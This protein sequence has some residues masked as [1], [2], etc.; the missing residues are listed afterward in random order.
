MDETDTRTE[1]LTRYP[2]A[3][4]H[5]VPTLRNPFDA[6]SPE[7]PQCGRANFAFASLGAFGAGEKLGRTLQGPCRGLHKGRHDRLRRSSSATGR[8]TPW[9][10][11]QPHGD[12]PLVAHVP[13][14]EGQDA[15][16]GPC[17]VTGHADENGDMTPVSDD[18]IRLFEQMDLI[19]RD[20][21]GGA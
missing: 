20:E 16:C 2:P 8:Q 18:V 12:L 14:A 21:E 7:P 15:I 19:R 6:V 4:P 3:I 17:F 10:P 11:D 1:G 5:T 13:R 9:P